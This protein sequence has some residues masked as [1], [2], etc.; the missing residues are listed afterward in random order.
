[1]TNLKGKVLVGLASVAVL[2]GVTVGSVGAFAATEGQTPTRVQFEEEG[3]IITPPNPGELSLVA[4]P[5]LTDFATHE[6]GNAVSHTAVTSPATRYVGLHDDR[7]DSAGGA[8]TW[9]L[10]AK[11]SELENIANTTQTINTGSIDVS[12]G[13]WNNW[14]M[15]EPVTTATSP[16][17]TNIT[18]NASAVRSLDL[19]GSSVDFGETTTSDRQGYALPIQSMTLNLASTQTS[20]SGQT[21]DGNITWTL[22][23]TI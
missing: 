23:N 17:S 14:T 10:T 1:M 8:G 13:T 16:T 3:H 20:W 19:G 4:V 7:P 11:A 15:G 22:S 12:V 18:P 5:A 9:K 6:A 2:G 21:F